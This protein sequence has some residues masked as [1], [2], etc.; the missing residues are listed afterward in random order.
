MNS[1]GSRSLQGRVAVVT[2]ASRG[3]GHEVA[4]RLASAGA[5]VALLARTETP[6]PKI[7]GRSVTP[8]PPSQPPAV[9]P[10]NCAATFAIPTPSRP[11]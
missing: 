10:C 6:N 11:P 9:S 3:I 5:S 4:I 2:G 8:L 7:A 1:V